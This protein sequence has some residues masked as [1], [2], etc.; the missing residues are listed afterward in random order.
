MMKYIYIYIYIYTEDN[1]DKKG[2]WYP[3]LGT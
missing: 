1:T 3:I 2:G